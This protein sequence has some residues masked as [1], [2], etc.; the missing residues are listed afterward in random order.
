M[1]ITLSPGEIREIN[2]QMDPISAAIAGHITRVFY[3]D[4]YNG[5]YPVPLDVDNPPGITK[6]GSNFR[7]Q[8][9]WVNDSEIGVQ[10][11][12]VCRIEDPDGGIDIQT[13]AW[14]VAAPPGAETIVG[15]SLPVTKIGSHVVTITLRGKVAEGEADLDQEIIGLFGTDLQLSLG[16]G[17]NV[18]LYTGA[19]AWLPDG[20]TNILS[21]TEIVWWQDPQ[22]NWYFYDAITPAGSTL[23]Q[24]YPY[25]EH[26]ITTTRACEWLLTP[27]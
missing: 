25:Q 17:A 15:I 22:G 19:W 2:I 18:I 9:S 7:L 10:P 26:I 21:F 12:L 4:S 23:N 27:W 1:S 6:V 11:Q 3:L 13:S 5:D 16:V 24:L 14:L 20:L 8:V